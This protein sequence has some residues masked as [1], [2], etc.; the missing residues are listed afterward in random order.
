MRRNQEKHHML[1]PRAKWSKESQTH[2][3]VRQH[4]SFM[5]RGFP[6]D[7]HGVLHQVIQ[8]LVVPSIETA[9]D[10][11]TIGE[12]SMKYGDEERMPAMLDMMAGYTKGHRMRD[13]QLEMGRIMTSF[14]AQDG[15]YLMARTMRERL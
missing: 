13:T 8:P 5:M 9:Y 11:L 7:W 14:A 1:F 12:D 2:R 4:P 10:L 6:G 3:D 15:I